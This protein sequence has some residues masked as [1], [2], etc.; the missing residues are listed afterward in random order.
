MYDQTTSIERFLAAAAAKQPAPGGG[1]VTALVA[2][3]SASMGEMSINYSLGKK[4]LAEFEGEL[5]PAREEFERARRMML[6]L[7][8][9]DQLAYEALTAARKLPDGS[10]DRRAAFDPALL[11][12]IRVPQAMAATGVAVLE[13]CDG[14]VNFVNFYLLSDLAVCADL[15][16]A[17][18]RCA[19]YNVRANLPDVA[20]PAERK[21]IEETTMHVLSR[22]ATLI[23]QVSPRIWARHAQGA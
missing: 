23:Q 21:R 10:P 11:A 6:Q 22:A 4:S 5:R 20:D 17:A 9:E 16:M 15:A 8:V 12:C 14:V 3:L 19:T 1:S 18:V 13:L 2:A 7:M